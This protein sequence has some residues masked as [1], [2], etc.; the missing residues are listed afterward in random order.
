M[1]CNK[2]SSQYKT[3]RELSFL[4]LMRERVKFIMVMF[5]ITMHGPVNSHLC[6]QHFHVNSRQ[7]NLK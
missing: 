2:M 5:K 4:V 1:K 3:A 7:Y 6:K